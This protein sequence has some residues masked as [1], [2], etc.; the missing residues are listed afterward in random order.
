MKSTLK[1]TA[2]LLAL[3]VLMAAAASCGSTPIPAPS[4]APVAVSTAAP[5]AGPTS[6]QVATATPVPTPVPTEEPTAA[7]T[8][9]YVG[10]PTT[11]D[12]VRRITVEELKAL[13]D[14]GADVAILDVRPRESYDLGH[15]EGA[16]SFPWKPQLTYADVEM[17]PW[18][19]LIV[20]YCDCGPG[21]ADSANVA[22]QLIELGS[23]MEFQVL[24]HPAIEGWI[25]LGYPT[26]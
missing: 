15:I 20:T 24:A 19:D 6:A 16:V 13:M 8:P 18:S 4:A 7:P 10:T 21:E 22:F 2:V 12:Q 9:E 5:V 23:E 3:A 17:L 26:E 11:P 25:E 1:C 14:S